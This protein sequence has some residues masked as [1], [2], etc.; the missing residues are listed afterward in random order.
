[1]SEET[2]NFDER[3]EVDN[4][5]PRTNIR[6]FNTSLNISRNNDSPKFNQTNWSMQTP[7][8]SRFGR[9][10]PNSTAR[11]WD[12]YG[13]EVITYEKRKQANELQ[14]KYSIDLN[15]YD[16]RGARKPSYEMT[17]FAKFTCLNTPV[18]LK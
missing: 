18:T 15:I 9:S 8:S 5:L 2:A 3:V 16:F 11:K 10:S 17:D 4:K 12:S 13:N 6:S 1:M 7:H 14:K